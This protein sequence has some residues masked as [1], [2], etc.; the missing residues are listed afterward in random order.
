MVEM[1]PSAVPPSKIQRR[2]MP[3]RRLPAFSEGLGHAE[4][5][6]SAVAATVMC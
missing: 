3:S 5:H 1:A 6:T 2:W 4:Q